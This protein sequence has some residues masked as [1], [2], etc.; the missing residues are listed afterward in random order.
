MDSPFQILIFPKYFSIFKVCLI[1]ESPYC[2]HNSKL[3][4]EKDSV[5]YLSHSEFMEKKWP[6][7][8]TTGPLPPR[9]NS[10][11]FDRSGGRFLAGYYKGSEVDRSH[12]PFNSDHLSIPI[13]LRGIGYLSARSSSDKALSP[14][15][16]EPYPLRTRLNIWTWSSSPLIGSLFPTCLCI[17]AFSFTIS[18]LDNFV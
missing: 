13:F 9:C 17:R 18:E 14:C 8:N 2:W 12:K 15:L 4:R 11:K 3:N 1:R 6:D 7:G 10:I 5:I 16:D